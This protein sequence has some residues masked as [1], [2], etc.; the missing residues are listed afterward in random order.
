M[1]ARVFISNGR[2]GEEGK[3]AERQKER[4]CE[5]QSIAGKERW[6][7]QYNRRLEKTCGA[8]V[9]LISEMIKIVANDVVPTICIFSLLIYKQHLDLTTSRKLHIIVCCT[10]Q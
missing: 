1:V 9:R 10:A 2:Q 3:T 8:N 6:H 5:R 7:R 4:V